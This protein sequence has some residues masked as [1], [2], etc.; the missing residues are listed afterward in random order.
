M[1]LPGPMVLSFSCLG[2][3]GA[4]IVK[5]KHLGLGGMLNHLG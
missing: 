3:S 2:I 4:L 1:R 5:S